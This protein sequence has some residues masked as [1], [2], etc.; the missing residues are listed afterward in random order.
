M[1]QGLHLDV[2]PELNRVHTCCTPAAHLQ[3]LNQGHFHPPNSLTA[4][5]SLSQ[6]TLRPTDKDLTG[7]GFKTL[8]QKL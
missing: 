3:A 2:V 6:G 5:S 1:I 4:L 8:F 7:H